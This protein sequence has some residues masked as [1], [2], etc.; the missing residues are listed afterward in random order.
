MA[1][2]LAV[3]TASA[4]Q[5]NVSIYGVLDVGMIHASHSG[6]TIND[7]M[8]GMSSGVIGTSHVGFR[9]KENLGDGITAGAQIES[10]LSTD[11][12]S[13]GRSSGTG[14]ANPVFGRGAN[15]FLESKTL[16]RITLG[17]QENAAWRTYSSLDSTRHSNIGGNP[18]FLSDGSSFGGSSAS[19][20][21]LSRYT[22][23]SFVGQALR[24]DSTIIDGFSVTAS[25]TFGGVP[26]DFDAGSSNQIILRHD[27][28]GALF[29]AVGHYRA[30]DTLG[31]VWGGNTYLGIGVRAAK[32]L[33]VTGNYWRLENPNGAGAANTKFDLY[34]AGIRYVV[35]PR[36]TTSVGVY[37]LKDR[38]NGT[39]GSELQSLVLRY[40]MSKHTQLYAALS[41]ISNK[42]SSGFA[43]WGGGGANAHSLATTQGLSGAGINQTAFAV[44]M[45]Y[46]F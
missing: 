41:G 27:S 11:D 1:V 33:V 4:A 18:I 45:R 9:S 29:G 36:V 12:G 25:R 7:S 46:G 26:G 17:R 5:S 20:V 44:G 39:N 14:S 23:G 24:Y 21:G 35:T 8:T 37:Q 13:Q 6:S 43:A 10:Q 34:N 15:V 40:D 32:D 30:Y 16:G 38:I 42:G 3:S 28:D 19:K 2:A 22:G 31:N